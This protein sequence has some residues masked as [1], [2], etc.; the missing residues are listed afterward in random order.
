MKRPHTPAPLARRAPVP[1]PPPESGRLRRWIHGALFDNLGLKFLSMVLAVTVFLLV[2]D[3]QD[4]EIT[5]PV[6][7]QYVLP[8]DR[9]LVSERV[10]ELRVTIRGPWRRMRNFHERELSRINIDLR[11]ASSGEIA[12][13]TDMIEVPS[14]LTVAGVTPRTMRVAFDRRV[15]KLVEIAPA[16]VGRPQ[17]GYMVMEVKAEPAT[18]T[19]RGG[20]R[21]L[22]ALSSVRTQ[23]VSLEGHTETFVEPTTLVPPDGIELV[24]SEQVMLQVDIDES[25]VT[26]QIRDVP[27]VA[28]GE[29]GVE[30]RW[31]L[32]PQQVD[33]T[34]TGALLAVE[35]AKA[36]MT[37]V[38]RVAPTERAPRDAEVV[39]E[40][41]PPGVGVRLS[42]ERI[43]L[44]PVAPPARGAGPAARP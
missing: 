44:T 15:E 16:I 11:K 35:K 2:N 33:V 3:D 36:A 40:G 41:V 28:Q 14:G 10:D 30:A 9:V 19:V 8:D 26:R 4:R 27:V 34:L 42:P 31:A 21:L 17:H 29:V 32:T 22:A 6:G 1:E 18:V 23:E 7:V 37:A 24:G 39:I 25:L 20:E 38:V 43:K 13:T 12:F 5:V